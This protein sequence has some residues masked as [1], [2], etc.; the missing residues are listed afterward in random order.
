[1]RSYMLLSLVSEA[2]QGEGLW[3]FLGLEQR[4]AEDDSETHVTQGS[5]QYN[6]DNLGWGL[7]LGLYL[8]Q[9]LEVLAAPELGWGL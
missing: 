4:G 5:S 2:W 7:Y 8:L 6:D 1:M 3:L 9:S